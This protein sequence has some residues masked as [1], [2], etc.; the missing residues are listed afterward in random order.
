MMDRVDI[1]DDLTA[2]RYVAEH[3]LPSIIYIDGDPDKELHV[4][5]ERV[6]GNCVLFSLSLLESYNPYIRLIL[7][8]LV[9]AYNQ[10]REQDDKSISSN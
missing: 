5:E 9:R 1:V 3:D 8:E 4:C 7:S 6:D 10:R 2:K